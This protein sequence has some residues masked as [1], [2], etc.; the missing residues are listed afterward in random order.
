MKSNWDD[1]LSILTAE[2]VNFAV[3]TA[4]LGSRF[5]AWLIDVMVQFGVLS[6]TLIVFG[7]LS[8]RWGLNTDF[9]HW[10]S[11]IAGAVMAIVVFLIMYGYYFFCE[12]LMRGQ[13]PGKHLLG[14]RVVQTSGLPVTVWPAL[15]RNLLR[16]VDFL[17]LFYG[18]GALVALLNDHNRRIGD[19]AAGTVVARERRGEKGR[20]IL[21]IGAAADA[22]LADSPETIALI[23][24]AD[25]NPFTP[26][27]FPSLT[28]DIE[29]SPAPIPVAVASSPGGATA[30]GAPTIGGHAGTLA[31]PPPPP[32]DARAAAWRLRLNDQDYELVQ[33]FLQRRGT[34][35]VQ[36][37]TRLGQN[38]ANRLCLK[39]GE[40]LPPA[41]AVEQFLEIVAS[42]LQRGR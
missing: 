39:L 15:V 17:P 1:D 41:H 20:Y 38:L 11:S 23:E 10:F 4:G 19:L 37:R 5:A 14:L 30:P 36:T 33:E 34:L 7:I 6:I 29:E 32:V 31:A 25:Y 3:E 21:D 42:S 13:T 35:G 26:A 2:N 40:P 22:M 8:I 28:G 16:I 18:A 12:W 27:A 24:G 9:E